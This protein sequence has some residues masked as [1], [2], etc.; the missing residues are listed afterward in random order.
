MET[1]VKNEYTGP[2][3]RSNGAIFIVLKSLNEAERILNA[4]LRESRI[5]DKKLE[6]FF[7]KYPDEEAFDSEEVLEEFSDI[8]ERLAG[9]ERDLSSYTRTA[10][11]MSIVDLESTVNRFCYFNLGEVTTDSIER[12][13][14][15]EKLEVAH[16]VLGLSSF[17]G[18]RCYQAM[19]AL[20][21]WRNAFVHG[22]CTDMPYN[23][24]KENHLKKPD[25]YPSSSDELQELFKLLD[26]YLLACKYLVKIS[27]HPYT[28]SPEVLWEEI[29]W[30]IDTLRTFHF[31][32]GILKG[33]RRDRK[34]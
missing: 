19:R 2:Y 13:S 18:N 7:E 3:W 14:L 16:A 31:E 4:M 34:K 22:K 12:L 28:S 17:K 11:L 8:Y 32:D 25:K 24:I 33:R 10:I 5:V 29:R 9:L 27:K 15:S 21:N 6:P 1:Q 30:Q 23:T 20:V 26:E